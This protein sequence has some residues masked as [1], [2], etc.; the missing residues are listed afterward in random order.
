MRL[1]NYEFAESL[2]KKEWL[3]SMQMKVGLNYFG[4]KSVIG[5]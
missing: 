4:G 2:D 3:N 5:K 1:A